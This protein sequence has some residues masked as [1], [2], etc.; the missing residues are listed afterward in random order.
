M[1]LKLRVSSTGG[2]RGERE[3]GG[4]IGGAKLLQKKFVCAIVLRIKLSSSGY[5]NSIGK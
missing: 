4:Y 1:T 3:V 5:A 2:E